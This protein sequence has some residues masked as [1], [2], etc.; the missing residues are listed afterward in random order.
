M[1][2]LP[3]LFAPTSVAIIGVSEN[4]N[5]IG[6]VIFENIKSA[7]YTGAIY[8]VNPKYTSLRGHQCYPSVSAI[9]HEVESVCIAVPAPLV[10]GVL[11][12]A[13]KK[14]IKTVIIISSGFAEQGEEGKARE[15]ELIQLCRKHN[16]RLL[17]PNCLGIL[18]AVTR[19]NLSFT[20]TSS[21]PGRIAVMS[22]SGA[23][24]T[25]LLDAAA[26]HSIGFS[27]IASVG[28]QADISDLDL[29]D[30]YQNN[31]D[32][33]V[34]VAYLE[35]VP[36]GIEL[37]KK[38]S[39]YAQPKPFIVIKPGK[40]QEARKAMQSHT[41]SIAN[42]LSTFHTAAAQFGIITVDSINELLITAVAFERQYTP[43]G[44]S[45]AIVTNAGGPGILATDVV[46]AHGLTIP[47]LSI[48]TRNALKTTLPNT[49]S[50]HNPL[51]L[52]GDA[53]AQRYEDALSTLQKDRNIDQILVILTPQFVTQIDETAKTILSYS[54]A[55]NKPIFPV[56]L[57]G[58]YTSAGLE[59]FYDKKKVCYTSIEDAVIAM[60][61]LG[62]FASWSQAHTSEESA[63]KQLQVPTN[64]KILLPKEKTTKVLPN[65]IT[66]EF[67]KEFTLP[68]PPQ[69]VCSNT[70]E[71]LSFL[72]RHQKVVLKLLNDNNPHKTEKNGIVT[73]I[74]NPKKLINAWEKLY[75]GEPL[76]IQK[77]ID[78]EQEL[79]IGVHKDSTGLGHLMILG[80]GGVETEVYKD[81]QSVLIP[82][83]THWMLQQLARTK[84]SK[85]L[86]GFRNKPPLAVTAFIELLHNIQKLVISYPEIT[87]IDCNPVLITEK[88]VFLVDIKIEV[89]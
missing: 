67:A 85:T 31:P 10:L 4:P 49:A 35:E 46:A 9:P 45:V 1:N 33:A 53:L 30:Y 50:I 27:H 11:T 6:S 19:T 38:Y 68:L 54:T 15:D 61:Q 51:D 62:K 24:C 42:S 39:Q 13:V 3:A 83:T 16:V 72:T 70:E 58:K 48:E 40:S 79:F 7:G 52:G 20:A 37:F 88:G 89:E 76:I 59:Y 81:L 65:T 25:A 21:Q 17:G 86:V 60:A 43:K 32:V 84:V 66:E 56:F 69:K 8:P 2:N 87:S 12:D 18:S 71:A 78:A 26:A 23:I 41:G 22:Q 74:H 5:K 34:I 29:L 77:Q 55:S 47:E 82:A 75:S 28:N 64:R 57:G 36:S 80:K 73:N 63:W 44:N 14:P